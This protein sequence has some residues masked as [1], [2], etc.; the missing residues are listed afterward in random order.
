MEAQYLKIYS[1]DMMKSNGDRVDLIAKSQTLLLEV[2]THFE[3][4]LV[5]KSS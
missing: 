3:G 1:F 4:N 5:Q 2:Q